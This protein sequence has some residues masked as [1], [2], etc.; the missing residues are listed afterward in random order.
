MS[1]II[2]SERINFRLEI[3]ETNRFPGKIATIIV[4]FATV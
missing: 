2:L 1:I 4:V 3:T